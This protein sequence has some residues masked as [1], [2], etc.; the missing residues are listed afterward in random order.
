MKRLL[1]GL[2]AILLVGGAYLAISHGPGA[3]PS[4]TPTPGPVKATTEVTA[5]GKVVPVR[6]AE[7]AAVTGG[8]VADVLV[9]EGQRVESGQVL[10]RLDAARAQAAVGAAQA[11][12]QRA[13]AQLAA[14][15][16]PPRL[17]D[18]DSAQAAVD[19]AR[20]Q[21]TKLQASARPETI[22]QARANLDAAKADLAFV[23]SGGRPE[24]ITVAQ[25][26]LDQAQAHLA[27]LENGRPEAIAGAKANLDAAQAKLDELKAGPTAQQI[28]VEKQ[29]IEQAKDAAYAAGVNKDGACNPAYPGYVCDT[30]KAQAAAAD[31][32]V[33]QAQAQL[34]VL[35]SPP[36]AEQLQQAQAAVD[37]ARSQLAQAQHPGSASDLAVAQ[38]A[39]DG[40]QAQLSLAK[41][42]ATS[43]DLARAQTAVEVA[44][45]Q[46]R[47]A[48][49]PYTQQDLD[50]A[51]A[52]V[53]QAAAQLAVVKAPARPETIAAAQA[54]VAAAQ[55][56]LDQANAALADLELKAPFAGVVANLDVKAG[57]F[58]Q[59]GVSFASV[60]DTSA[61]QI[62]T[63]DLTELNV[64]RIHSG[65]AAT[66]TFD[67]I[68]GLTLPATVERIKKLGVE[69]KGDILYTV[70]LTP[71][72]PDDRLLWNMTAAVSI[73]P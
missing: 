48:Q 36:T 18:V 7:L 33:S 43:A 25:S 50:A 2:V 29:A 65:Q 5:Q 16:A 20:A 40:A 71:N 24:A 62:D 10:V 59:P 58:V 9:E 22:A 63:T 17:E 47:L 31:T 11:G 46:L 13:R 42:P 14:L 54:D 56:T 3:A 26:G 38:K 60:A 53:Q 69:D 52:Q 72:K 30:A 28:A 4:T 51:Q 64:E 66:L 67:A 70:T 21:L 41:Q 32:A 68:P 8:T 57:E 39:V 34:A 35:T 73:Q 55:S 15:E 19:S 37:A 44:T 27:A 12:L 1:F 49:Q 6:K 61:W 23:Q 45:Q